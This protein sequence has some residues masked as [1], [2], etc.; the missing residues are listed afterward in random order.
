MKTTKADSTGSLKRIVRLR[1]LSKRSLTL[2]T[3]LM[4]QAEKDMRSSD[5]RNARDSVVWLK[6]YLKA[7]DDVER[8]NVK[9]EGRRTL[10]LANT[11][12]N[13]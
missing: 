7:L 11:N 12:S 9:D 2:W 13:L 3:R 1:R 5:E 10:D 6:G 4:K 8:P